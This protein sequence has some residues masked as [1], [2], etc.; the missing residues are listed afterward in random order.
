QPVA[1]LP[2][3]AAAGGIGQ[4]HGEPGAGVLQYGVT[5]FRFARTDPNA[6]A[7]MHDAWHRQTVAAGTD[8]REE[9]ERP[10]VKKSGPIRL[11]PSMSSAR[12]T[13]EKFDG[14]G[15]LL[16][17]PDGR[18]PARR[19]QIRHLYQ[20][21]RQG[22]DNDTLDQEEDANASPIASDAHAPGAPCRLRRSRGGASHGAG[23][24]QAG[25]RSAFPR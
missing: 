23:L 19:R 3:Y 1:V 4:Q 24:C 6:G 20:S 21:L 11:E 16:E 12:R 7:E 22:L 13:G 5:K 14:M 9:I 15:D 2:H 25:G 17:A 10:A 8:D 18:G